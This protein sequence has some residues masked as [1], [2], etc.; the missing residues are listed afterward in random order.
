VQKVPIASQR[1]QRRR[2]TIRVQMAIAR[3]NV[4]SDPANIRWVHSKRTPPTKCGTLMRYPKDVGQS[5]TDSPASLLVT[6]APAVMTTR[7]AQAVNTAKI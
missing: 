5:G 7:V 4:I 1:N 6:R 3:V 2:S